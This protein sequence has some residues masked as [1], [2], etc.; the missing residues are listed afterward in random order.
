MRTLKD[1][2]ILYDAE[3][4]MCN[5]YTGAFVK[6]GMLDSDG[7]AAYQSAHTSCPQIDLQRAVNEIALVNRQTGEVVYGVKSLFTIIAHAFPI[8]KP[9]FASRIFSAAMSRL[10][11]FIS[12][13]RRVIIPSQEDTAS[14]AVQPSFKKGYRIAYLIVTWFITATVYSCY[15]DAISLYTLR[16]G[17]FNELAFYGGQL[18]LQAV[19]L[20]YIEKRAIWNYLGHLMT[21]SLAGSLLLIPVLLL[22]K[23]NYISENLSFLCSIVVA[24][25]MLAEHNCRVHLLGL[26]SLLSV[27]WVFYRILIYFF[28]IMY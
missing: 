5:L 18:L 15:S 20:L 26:G 11:A 4:P 27:T 23:A 17:F 8:C 2:L 28:P 10:Y 19:V 14:F 16:S 13:N 21:I 25:L 24:V 7:R 9:L 6:S 22:Y 12:Y 1:H 3:C